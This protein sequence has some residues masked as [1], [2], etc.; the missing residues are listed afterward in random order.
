MG[1][2][3]SSVIPRNVLFSQ[4][5][6]SAKGAWLL[7]NCQLMKWRLDFVARHGRV[8]SCHCHCHIKSQNL[9]AAEIRSEFWSMPRCALA[10]VSEIDELS[11]R[12]Q[13]P[14]LNVF[15]HLQSINCDGIEAPRLKRCLNKNDSK[16]CSDRDLSD[17]FLE[18]F[19]SVLSTSIHTSSWP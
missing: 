8:W 7:A 12:S 1:I 9:A 2:F 5:R 3:G 4:H 18:R 6:I 10:G 11:L 17:N 14:S 19:D 15:N 13:R 16:F